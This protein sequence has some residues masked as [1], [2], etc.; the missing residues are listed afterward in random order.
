MTNL[1][2]FLLFLV[3]IVSL[4]SI[5]SFQSNNIELFKIP[6]L[7]SNDDSNDRKFGLPSAYGQFIDNGLFST[8]S[9]QL[10]PNSG[11]TAAP[12]PTF[13]PPLKKCDTQSP[14][15]TDKNLG[16]FDVAKYL[17]TGDVNKD[18]IKGN[19]LDLQIFADL[20]KD[21]EVEIK[22]KNAPYKAN[23]LSDVGDDNNKKKAKVKLDEIATVCIDI[24]KVE[25]IQKKI[26]I[27]PKESQVFQS[28]DY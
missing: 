26:A 1:S 2:I 19:D 22:G 24:Q 17:I 10:L 9:P 15:S 11:A 3:G 21:D 12:G 25:N 14:T 23:W 28:L 4:Y 20:V 16:G 13:N 5:I 7:L 8:V 6:S 18:K 27:N